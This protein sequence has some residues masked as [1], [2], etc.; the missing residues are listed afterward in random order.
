MPTPSTSNTTDATW[1]DIG[2][3]ARD[4]YPDGPFLA[5]FIQHHRHRICPIDRVTAQIPPGASILDIGCGGGLLIARLAAEARITAAHGID[6]SAPAIVLAQRMAEHLAPRAPDTDL[7]FEHRTVQ[8]GLPKRHYDAVCLI[9]VMHH[10]PPAHQ[11]QAFRDAAS[12]VRPGGRLVYKDMADRR[13][14]HSLLNRLHDML[15]ARQ[16]IHYLP[17]ERAE[18]IAASE[19]LTLVHAEDITMLWYAHELRVFERPPEPPEIVR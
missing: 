2:Q 15:L 5:R 17:M 4:L 19:G 6:S 18:R 7:Q 16:W 11:E 14:P 10:V 3:L 12:R 8:Q 9:D 1:H 13:F